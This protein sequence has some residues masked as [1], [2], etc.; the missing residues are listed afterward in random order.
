[1]SNSGVFE[2]FRK[3]LL[4]E[5]NVHTIVALPAK[6]IWYTDVKTV[7]LFVDGQG[8]TSEVLFV[9]VVPPIG[10]KNFTKKKP[11]TFAVLEPY[12]DVVR[13]RENGEHAWSESLDALAMRGY[14]LRPLRP[15][16]DPSLSVKDADERIGVIRDQL[17][18]LVDD[19]SSLEASV[20]QGLE[21]EGQMWETAK[22]ADILTQRK[23]KITISDD[24]TYKRV[25]V[26]LHGR[27]LFLRDQVKGT[28]IKTKTQYLV[29]PRQLLVAEIDAKLGGL[30]IVPKELDRAIVSSHYFTFDLDEEKC[31]L[32][33]LDL[34]CRSE[35]LVRQIGAKGATNY[36]SIRPEQLLA[37]EIPLPATDDQRALAR[38]I[39]TAQ[40]VEA[41]AS[42]IASAA[43]T[44]LDDVR[45][46]V[47]AGL[48][49]PAHEPSLR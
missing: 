18:P 23:D 34:I 40:N 41:A 16:P 24:E 49:I 11:L 7:L 10:Q 27:G 28:E 42:Q 45:L 38:L 25:R 36:A 48:L 29:S 2:T 21:G 12:L 43:A 1:M 37:L 6:G 44:V 32:D 17:S 8:P 15:A 31:L 39:R 26:A 19:L 13:A 14:D 30:G 35:Y 22:L 47:L 9:E 20:R 5:W 3:R 46:G 33:W 4:S